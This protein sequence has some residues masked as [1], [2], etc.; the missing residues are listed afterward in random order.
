MKPIL[1]HCFV[2]GML[3][4]CC[5]CGSAALSTQ[6]DPLEDMEIDHARFNMPQDDSLREQLPKGVFTGI[7]VG[8][9]RQ[10]LEA[11]LGEPEGL[12]VTRVV[13]NSPAVAA[14]IRVGD[15]LLEATVA[16]QNTTA[17]AWPSDWVHLEETVAPGTSIDL[18]CDRAGRDHET[19]LVPT[20]RLKPPAA[21]EGRQYREEDKVGLVVRNVSEVEAHQAGLTRG[22]GCVVVGLA[23]Q[24]PW[25]QDG[26]LFGDVIVSFNGQTVRDPQ[27][28]LT[29]L[30]AAGKGDNVTL[31]V[32]REGQVVTI[33][34]T[35]S[36]RQ[37]EVKEV[38]IPLIYAY[39][40]RRGI[41]KTSLLLDLI[42][43]RKTAVATQ[44]RL[45]WLISFTSGDANRLEEV[46]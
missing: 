38:N 9:A 21:L 37:Q 24:S 15:I 33:K 43:V 11:Q 1:L 25:R 22:Q 42:S 4:T 40:N 26:V 5:G 27:A 39:E 10:S 36:R 13:E 7:E 23:R 20:E 8:D 17:L 46:K 16:N 29:A 2:L 14:D 12:L 34:T 45:C 28:L 3:V 31:V 30:N 35:V 19:T 41:E 18:L 6:A 32:Y 44:L